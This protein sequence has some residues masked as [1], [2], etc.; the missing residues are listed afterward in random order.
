ML[1]AMNYIFK[2][3]ENNANSFTQASAIFISDASEAP[4]YVLLTFTGL[5]EPSIL[6]VVCKVIKFS[7]NYLLF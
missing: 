6:F 2:W 4:K 1:I 5:C 3:S 7:E